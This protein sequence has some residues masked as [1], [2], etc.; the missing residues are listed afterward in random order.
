LVFFPRQ[1]KL[2]LMFAS[3]VFIILT[4]LIHLIYFS[5]K[6]G[7]KQGFGVEIGL[8]IFS[9][10]LA[11]FGAK[12][13]H[14]QGYLLSIWVQIYMYFFFFY[15]FLHI[16][17][18]RPEEIEQLIII[19]AIAWLALFIIQYVIYPRVIFDTRITAERG[20]VRIFV[21]GGSFASLMYFYF[22]LYYFREKKA[23]YLIFC[24]IFLMIPILQGTRSSILTLLLGTS[25]F[26]LFSRQVTSKLS[27]F[28]LMGVSLV[29]VFFLF[30]DIFMNLIQ[31][32]EHQ[33]AQETEDIRVRSAKFFL[34]DFYPNKINY[35]IGN[36]EG[37]MMSGYG[38]RIMYYKINYGFYQSD[39]GIIGAY[40][41]YGVLYIIAIFLMMRKI[42]VTRIEPRYM[43]IKYYSVLLTFGIIMGQPFIAPHS[44]VTIVATLYLI[45]VSNYKIMTESK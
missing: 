32:S 9:S 40:T 44:I 45:D 5:H 27:I 29:I 7:F 17:R 22:L 43:Y 31:V 25:I 20:T 42:F 37:H 41:K 18:I 33:A 16:L 15:Y 11:M 38:M 36:G 30:Q 28:F 14:Q 6:K 13:G 19:M 12:W 24:F 39:I 21:P 4:V 1:V 3:V 23:R 8:L 26:I 35:I 34:T 10:I 2:L